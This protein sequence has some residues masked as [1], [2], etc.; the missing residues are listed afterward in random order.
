MVLTI[1]FVLFLFQIAVDEKEAILFSMPTEF[2]ENGSILYASLIDGQV[3]Q[4]K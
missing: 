2:R 4:E 3:I 1:H